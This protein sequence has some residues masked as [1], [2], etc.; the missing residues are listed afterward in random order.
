MLRRVAVLVVVALVF[1]GVPGRG[2]VPFAAALENSAQSEGTAPD[3]GAAIS[4]TESGD[5]PQTQPA[6]EAEPAAERSDPAITPEAPPGEEI[7]HR[8]TATSRTFATATA[9]KFRTEVFANPIHYRNEAGKWRRIDPRLVAEGSGVTN[10]A[11]TVDVDIAESAH[12]EELAGVQLA[13]GLGVAF[14]VRGA[15]D[16][17]GDADARSVTFDAVLPRVDITLTSI[18][19]GVKE[20]LVLASP[21]APRVF[22]FPLT[23]DGLTPSIGHDGGVV[24]RDGAGKSRAVIPPGWMQD[25]SGSAESS[26]SMGVAYA[27]V[28]DGTVLRVTLDDAW[29]DEPDRVWPVTVDPT[30]VRTQTSSGGN[31]DTWVEQ[32]VTTPGTRPTDNDLRIGVM[33][34]GDA[35]W[36]LLKFA[37]LGQFAGV[38]VTD[39][40]LVLWNWESTTCAN[41]GTE[42]RRNLAVVANAT[43]TNTDDENVWTA[44]GV[45]WA[46][47]PATT[48][49][50]GATAS[51]SHGKEPGCGNAALRFAMT[52]TVANL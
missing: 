34:D 12:A 38:T 10:A 52:Q 22:E 7:V 25:A 40:D 42:V 2:P 6:P 49:S 44:T 39:A 14:G 18:P 15:A 30:I 51:A 3:A 5:V 46:S 41:A 43:A 47:K 11:D 50:G 36:S 4:A 32:G 9:E 33:S 24:L 16:V 48:S 13:D 29:L 45:T 20:E 28:E 27:L 1:A 26:V 31:G 8:R 23:L 37:T 19:G 17:P 21:D 35:R